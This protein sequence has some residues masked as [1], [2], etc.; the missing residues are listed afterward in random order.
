MRDEHKVDLRL[1]AGRC[2]TGCARSARAT[3]PTAAAASATSWSP[4]FVNPLA[5]ALFR[6]PLEGRKTVTVTALAEDENR[7]MTVTLE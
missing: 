1:D 4:L 3:W 5:R 2:A 6:F 7:I